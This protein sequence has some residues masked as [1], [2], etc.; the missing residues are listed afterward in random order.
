E[1][2]TGGVERVDRRVDAEFGDLARQHGGGV[3][4]REGGRRRRVG[5]VVCRHVYGLHR[6]D[7]AL[8]GG[9]DA[10]LQGAHVGRQRRLIAH[11]RRNASEQRRYLGTRLGKAEDVV[12]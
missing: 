4:V 2:A 9:G 8:L 10:L 7:R 12:H 1:N 11:R 6:G 3:Q 5:Q